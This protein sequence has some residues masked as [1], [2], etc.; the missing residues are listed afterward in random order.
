MENTSDAAKVPVSFWIVAGLSLVWNSFGGFDY[1]M[2][3]TRNEAWLSMIGNYQE[4]VA[5]MDG[6]PLWAEIGYGLG[7]WG[8][9][10]GSLLLLL[11]SRH[12][13]TAFLVSLI[14]AAVSFTGQMQ[15]PLPPSLDTGA[16]AIMPVIV[17]AVI[18][19]LWW[20]ARR[21]A[22]KGTLK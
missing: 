1:I 10:A 5:W 21:E 19:A 12:A 8:S 17:M 20:F 6:F 22:A 4:V 18:L 13:V 14:G 15:N 16:G 7:V 2:S 9:V 11:R 3:Q